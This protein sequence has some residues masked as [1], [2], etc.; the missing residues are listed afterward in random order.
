MAA[1]VPAGMRPTVTQDLSNRRICTVASDGSACNTTLVT[2][3]HAAADVD[4]ADHRE[5]SVPWQRVGT[6]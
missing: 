6:A 2:E 4:R 5:Q 3:F 1:V